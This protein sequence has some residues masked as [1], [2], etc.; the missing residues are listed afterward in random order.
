MNEIKQYQNDITERIRSIK[1]S[2]HLMMDGAVAHSMR[3][4]GL[5]YNVNW[6]V[7]LPRLREKADEIGKNGTLAT[8]LPRQICFQ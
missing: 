7:T 1:Q 2:F 5:Q 3:E 4:K 6:G 8:A